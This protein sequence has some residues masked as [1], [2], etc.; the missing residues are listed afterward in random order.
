MFWR[1]LDLCMKKSFHTVTADPTQQFVT[2]DMH[3]KELLR[4]M[5]V[6]H[7]HVPLSRWVNR[8]K[9]PTLLKCR[10]GRTLAGKMMKQCQRSSKW[11]ANK[12]LAEVCWG[13]KYLLSDNRF[14]RCGIVRQMR[15]ERRVCREDSFY[16]DLADK[17]TLQGQQHTASRCFEE[18]LF[19]DWRS[20]AIWEETN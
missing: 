12:Q 19:I 6:S 3:Q 8:T 5:I 7:A 1:S 10:V 16:C 2:W 11:L 4:Q 17:E 20:I 14:K 13:T 18:K 15:K 9:P